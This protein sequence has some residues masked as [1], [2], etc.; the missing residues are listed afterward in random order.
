M[1]SIKLKL[2]KIPFFAGAI[3]SMIC[4]GSNAQTPTDVTLLSPPKMKYF[5]E[6]NGGYLAGN[7]IRSMFHVKNGFSF[8]NHFDAAIGVG[9]ESYYSGRF[10]PLFLEG[11]YTV[12]NRK[13]SPFVA[14]SG[15]YLQGVGQ[16]NQYYY[17]TNSRLSKGFSTGAKV[18][19]K[20]QFSKS[21]SMI[22]S[23]GYR[24][25]YTENPE[26][27][28]YILPYPNQEAEISYN[29]NRFELAIGFIFH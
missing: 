15:G 16:Q 7:E 9:L 11:R 17:Q 6:V 19:I 27:M 5:C 10:V 29:M 18:G 2:R 13:T 28:Y 8:G 20:H 22:T 26:L 25:S 1:K 14:I 3:F 12:L 4:F 24:Y 23:F 21:I